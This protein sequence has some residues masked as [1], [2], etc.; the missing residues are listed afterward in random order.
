MDPSLTYKKG[1][2]YG[3]TANEMRDRLEEE[4]LHQLQVRVVTVWRGQ[5]EREEDQGQVQTGGEN[6][7]NQQV[8]KEPAMEWK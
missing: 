1:G 5:E 4:T 8:D 2:E 3:D 6:V 7:G